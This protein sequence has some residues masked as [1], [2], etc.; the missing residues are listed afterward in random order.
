MADTLL[1][2]FFMTRQVRLCHGGE[3]R[4][5]V[6]DGQLP[7]HVAG[8]EPV[9]ARAARRQMWVPLVEKV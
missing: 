1:L 6:I 9:F 7:H 3:W 2:L 8:G 5:L 4:H